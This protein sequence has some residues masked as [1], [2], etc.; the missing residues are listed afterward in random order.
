MKTK[1]I[2]LFIGLLLAAPVLSSC[3]DSYLDREPDDQVTEEQVFTRFDKAQAILTHVY[4]EATDIEKPINY[5]FHFGMAGATDECEGINVENRITDEFNEGDWS[6]SNTLYNVWRQAFFAI[7]QVNLFLTNVKKY[8]TPD[9]PMESGALQRRIGEAYFM[10][11]YIHY[12]LMKDYGEIPYMTIVFKEGDQ[13][14]Y[15]QQCVHD[16]V[17]SICSDCQRAMKYVNPWNKNGDKDFGR[18]DQGACLGLMAVVR[19]MDACPLWNGASDKYHYTGKRIF[20]DRYTYDASRWTKAAE[21]AKAVINFS[22]RGV[23]RFSLYQN[24]TAQDFLCGLDQQNYNNSTVYERLSR[25]FLTNEENWNLYQNEAVWFVDPTKDQNW[26]GDMYPPSRD[27]QS[28]MQ[29]VQEQVDEYEC[30][31]KG[32][33]GN[34]YGYSIFSDQAKKTDDGTVIDKKY[35]RNPGHKYY[36]DADPYINRDPRFYR[37]ILYMG[38]PFR[39]KSANATEYINTATGTNKIGATKATTTGYYLRKFIQEH[40]IK[41][42]S[43]AGYSVIHPIWRLPEFIYIYAE[44]INRTQ[45]PNKEIYDMINNVRARSFMAPMAPEAMTDASV[46]QN[47]IDREWRVEFFYENKRFFRTRLYLEPIQ[48]QEL[49][50]ESTYNSMDEENA[51]QNFISAGYGPYPKCQRMINGMRPV[52]DSNGFIVVDGKHYSM[53]RFKEENRVFKINYFLYPIHRDEVR[54]SQ[55]VLKQNPFWSQGNNGD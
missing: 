40:W 46:M 31:A 3:N 39:N 28:R 43:T 45:G 11:A 24:Y 44:A 51:A 4:G 37:D 20:E 2:K 21:A 22:V 15:P 14:N 55:G 19:Y 33:D 8:N 1:Y 34:V 17:D 30:F 6:E 48:P 50:K 18:V 9:D 27:G 26:V 32:D 10:R 54:R 42:G 12:I 13:S 36:D 16:V 53:R 25:M 7:R 38:A 5:F 35:N 47:Y 41:G 52:E 29:P 23:K 49:E